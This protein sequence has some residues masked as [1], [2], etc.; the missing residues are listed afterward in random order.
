MSRMNALYLHVLVFT[1]IVLHTASASDP[2]V[3]TVYGDVRGTTTDR[4]LQFLGIPF[5]APPIGHLR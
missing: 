4:S 1:C 2:L 3:R 5:A